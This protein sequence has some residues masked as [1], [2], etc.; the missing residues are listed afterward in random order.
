MATTTY[1]RGS[2]LHFLRDPGAEA[3]PAAWE[4]W[5]DGCLRIENGRVAAAGPADQVMRARTAQ[6]TLHNHRGKL[7]LPGF[8][9]TQVHYAQLDVIDY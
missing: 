7:I 3:D 6:G 5:D 2:I 4:Y 9:D 8:V 1:L